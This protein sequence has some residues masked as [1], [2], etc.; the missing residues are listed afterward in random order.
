MT[1]NNLAIIFSPVLGT[2]SD[3]I[4]HF[5]LEYD[6]IFPPSDRPKLPPEWPNVNFSRTEMVPLNKASTSTEADHSIPP[7]TNHVPM[8]TCK[9]HNT[10]GTSSLS[11]SSTTNTGS[12]SHLSTSGP[13][14]PKTNHVS[15][16]PP[17][18]QPVHKTTSLAGF[19]GS[20][21]NASSPGRNRRKRL[22]AGF[23]NPIN[24]QNPPPQPP[25]TIQKTQ[26]KQQFKAPQQAPPQK[27]LPQ[28]KKALP[29]PPQ[30]PQPVQKKKPVSP[31]QTLRRPLPTLN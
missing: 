6:Q 10:T 14:P 8:P 31:T 1:E 27:P 3:V 2:S 20:N 5:V 11:L 12:T 17:A 28:Q 4:V 7:K 29:T 15:P 16:P 9:T 26:P 23:Y 30:Q 18:P 13:H 25:K 24:V 21:D 19:G 22:S